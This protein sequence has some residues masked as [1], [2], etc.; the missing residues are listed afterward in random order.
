M[1]GAASA[2]PARIWH[3]GV[4]GVGSFS[5]RV[6]IKGLQTCGEA[7]VTALFGPT[8]EKVAAVAAEH[9]VPA[10]YISFAAFLSHP[11]LDAI[12]ICTPNDTHYPLSAQ[13]LEAGKHIIC[14]KPLAL[15][16]GQAL[17]LC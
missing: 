14:E 8:R 2:D 6:V 17:E 5:Q 11:E 4:A 16:A 13:V 10:A 12:A 15:S 3:I 9:G 7:R 1:E